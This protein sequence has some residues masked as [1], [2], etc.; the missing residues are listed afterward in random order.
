MTD[1]L[2][3]AVRETWEGVYDKS[4]QLATKISEHCARTGERFDAIIVVPRGSYYPV[5]IISRE[6]GFTATELL[7]ACVESYRVGSTQRQ[8][9]FKIGQMPSDN[10]IAGKNLLIID[11]VCD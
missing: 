3:D 2:D 11:E 4:L 1:I 6:L 7:H 8:A 9:K 5:N 10:Q